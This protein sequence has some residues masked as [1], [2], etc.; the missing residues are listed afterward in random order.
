MNKT[1]GK[2]GIP[3]GINKKQSFN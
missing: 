2:V 3:N 1:K